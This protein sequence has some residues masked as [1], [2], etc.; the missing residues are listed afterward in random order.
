MGVKQSIVDWLESV[1]GPTE[2]QARRWCRIRWGLLGLAVLAEVLLWYVLYAMDVNHPPIW[3]SVPSDLILEYIP[4]AQGHANLSFSLR[5]EMPFVFTVGFVFAVVVALVFLL[6]NPNR[7]ALYAIS[8]LLK[9]PRGRFLLALFGEISM[10]LLVYFKLYGFAS[11][12]S[13]DGDKTYLAYID[14]SPLA[15]MVVWVP[16]YGL[17]GAVLGQHLVLFRDFVVRVIQK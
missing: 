15:I 6:F 12:I 2:A 17:L 14:E 1:P 8:K 16:L 7:V 5:H 13:L 9:S 4:A 3:L 11:E 10:V